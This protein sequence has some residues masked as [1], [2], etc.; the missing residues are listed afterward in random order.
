[1][2]KCRL[3]HIYA[4]IPKLMKESLRGHEKGTE[5]I[6]ALITN[7]MRGIILRNTPH[8]EDLYTKTLDFK[9]SSHE[10]SLL[11]TALRVE[12]EGT[13]LDELWFNVPTGLVYPAL[14]FMVQ[15]SSNAR[16]QHQS[17]TRYG[18]LPSLAIGSD[19][20]VYDIDNAYIFDAN[21]KSVKIENVETYQD[22]DL[23]ETAEEYLNDRGLPKKEVEQIKKLDFVPTREQRTVPLQASDFKKIIG[24]LNKIDAGVYKSI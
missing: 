22:T 13:R 2:E 16:I 18:T 3:L 17:T 20:V 5:A 14:C 24:Y 1:M 8:L 4:I 15:P 21:G 10:R 12:D 19:N 9:N 6:N 11:I 23:G 7:R